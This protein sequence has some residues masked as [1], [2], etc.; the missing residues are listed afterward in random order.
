MKKVSRKLS[1]V[2]IGEIID[3]QVEVYSDTPPIVSLKILIKDK[4]HLKFARPLKVR[5]ELTSKGVHYNE[6][7]Q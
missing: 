5:L 6:M 7:A 1:E 4:C 3:S 2:I